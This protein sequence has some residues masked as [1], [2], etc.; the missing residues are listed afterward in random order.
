[1]RTTLRPLRVLFVLFTA[2]LALVAG[3]AVEPAPGEDTPAPATAARPPSAPEPPPKTAAPT[4]PAPPAAPRPLLAA[5]FTRDGDVA[6]LDAATGAVVARSPGAHAGGVRDL[7]ADPWH[8]RLLAFEADE[9]GDGG[10]IT[11]ISVGPG[12]LGAREHRAWVDGD[13]RLAASPFGIVVFE[14]GY[15]ARWRLLADGDAPSLGRPAPDPLSLAVGDAPEGFGLRALV[16][17]D[18]L[19][20]GELALASA[21]LSAEG[22]EPPALAGLGVAA[23]PAP[24][25]TRLVDAPAL[26]LAILAEV[27]RGRL[28][29]RPI[30]DG[31]ARP[32]VLVRGALPARSLAA[33]VEHAVALDGGRFVALLVSSP[34]RVIAVALGAGGAPTGVSAFDLPGDVRVEG[35]FFSRDLLRVGARRLL[36]ATSRGVVALDL[37]ERDGLPR[38]EE[39]DA[40]RGETLAGPLVAVLR[41]G[42]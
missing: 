12:G 41:A 20:G 40:F 26:G 30:V 7:V 36:A 38:L 19:S 32:A 37:S 24:T 3:C 23:E 11:T 25:A 27:A 17:R 4:W 22:L 6:E 14:D 29:L 9:D 13:A 18:G 34:S 10:E 1:M 2:A 5:A 31:V 8:H 16:V 15:G 21:R 28:W 42:D 39:D 33:R 35:R